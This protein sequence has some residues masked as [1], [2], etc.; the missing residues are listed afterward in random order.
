MKIT[1]EEQAALDAVM[2]MKFGELMAMLIEAT[3][4]PTG[5]AF[6]Q[7]TMVAMNMNFQLAAMGL[8]KRVAMLGVAKLLVTMATMEMKEAL[9]EEMV[10]E[11]GKNAN[12]SGIRPSTKVH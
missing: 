10:K 4:G 2:E 12:T 9:K 11:E 8:P 5:A 1:T 7:S 3:E 6:V